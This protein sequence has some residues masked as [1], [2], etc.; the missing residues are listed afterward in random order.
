MVT[1]WVSKVRL[2]NGLLPI[3]ALGPLVQVPSE[4]F[5]K[6][7]HLTLPASAA[8]ALLFCLAAF[9]ACGSGLRLDGEILVSGI[10][11]IGDD[12]ALKPLRAAGGGTN[13]QTVEQIG[14][15]G[16]IWFLAR[17]WNSSSAV[18]MSLKACPASGSYM[19]LRGEDETLG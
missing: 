19:R 7:S 5:R 10:V 3:F 1:R 17:A 18:N 16:R 2:G 12:I 6:S 13:G 14:D 8:S 4:F 11:S 9:L 15:L